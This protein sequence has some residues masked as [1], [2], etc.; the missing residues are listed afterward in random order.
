MSVADQISSIT[1][2]VQVDEIIEN[3]QSQID[4]FENYLAEMNISVKKKQILL[5]REDIKPQTVL[6]NF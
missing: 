2:N 6:F 1:D 4:E 5:H 3:L